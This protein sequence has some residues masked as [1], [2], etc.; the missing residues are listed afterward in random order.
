HAMI[1]SQM[2]DATTESGNEE[3]MQA[4]ARRSMN[5]YRDL[6]DATGFWEWYTTITPIDQIS[7]LPIAS[8]PV[9]RGSG[10]E[11]QFDDLRAIPWVCAWTQIRL[12]V[13]GWYGTGT[14]LLEA[15]DGSPD[16]ETRLQELYRDWAFFRAVV[17]NAERELA[18]AR[19]STAR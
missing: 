2:P 7:H 17:D 6:I 14:A 5:A 10:A 3:L 11:V 12:L 18:R 1:I 4:I 15:M 8:R 19:L 13:P 16:I 9:S